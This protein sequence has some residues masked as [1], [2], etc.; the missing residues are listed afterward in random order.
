VANHERMFKMST[1]S[2]HTWSQ[3]VIH[4]SVIFYEVTDKN[5]LASF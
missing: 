5:N 3:T 1:T 2:T 4:W